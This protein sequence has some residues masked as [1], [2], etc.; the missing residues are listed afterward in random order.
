MFNLTH[1]SAKT[2]AFSIFG[3]ALSYALV[4]NSLF[5]ASPA[6]P[7]NPELEAKARILAEKMGVVKEVCFGMDDKSDG[8]SLGFNF[9]WSRPVVVIK[10]DDPAAMGTIGHELAHI[11]GQHYMQKLAWA[12]AGSFIMFRQIDKPLASFG[13]TCL[14]IGALGVGLGRLQEK[15]ADIKGAEFLEA[16]ELASLIDHYN[17]VAHTGALLY[18][19]IEKTPWYIRWPT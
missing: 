17:N 16:Q 7:L 15:Q 12:I 9:A 14:F 6:I 18:R 11:Q 13:G 10:K 2:M 1:I 19:A 4:K 3:L 8:E 5:N